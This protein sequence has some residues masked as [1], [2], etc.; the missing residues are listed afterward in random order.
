MAIHDFHHLHHLLAAMPNRELRA[1]AWTLVNDI[2]LLARESFF[3]DMPKNESAKMTL[4]LHTIMNG[5]LNGTPISQ[6]G[7]EK[8]LGVSRPA[9]RRRL[10]ELEKRAC[11]EPGW[12]DGANPIRINMAMLAT[13]EAK[14]RLRRLL[15]LILDAAAALSKLEI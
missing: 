7:L 6:R 14:E 12:Q 11:I 10:V 4:L 8:E 3:A 5:H 15:Q 1:L 9:V 2:L 13:P